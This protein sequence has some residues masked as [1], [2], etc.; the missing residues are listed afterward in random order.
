MK[1]IAVVGSGIAGI[2]TSYYL[3][4]LGFDVS[5]FEAGDHFG[6]H[7]HTH[8]IE[9]K[10]KTFPV[11]TG[12]LVHNDRTYPNLIEF[13]KE[14]EIEVFNSDMS[15]SVIEPNDNISWAGTNLLTVFGQYKNILSPRFYSFVGEILKFNKHGSHYLELAEQ[16]QDLSLGE[17]LDRHNYSENFK[18]WYLLPMGGCIWS[19]PV[20][21]MLEFPAHSFLRFCINHGLLQVTD[22]PQWKTVTGGC[23]VY[24]EKALSKI[25]K[26]Y[27]N[28][29]VLSAM[30]FGNKVKLKTEQR[31]EEFDACFFCG[32]PPQTL[33]IIKD[34]NPK[35]THILK[36]FE[37][38]PNTAVLHHDKTVL[39]VKRFWS[40]WNY[41]A[42]EV[43]DINDE[44]SVS[45]SYLI[46]QLQPLPLAK[47]DAVI[48]TLNPVSEI[49]PDKIWK[50]LEY[51]HPVFDSKAVKAQ[52]EIMKIQGEDN[53]Y[54]AGAWMRYG[55][56]EDGILSAK[57]V[58]N[59]FL[60]KEEESK[61][62]PI[63]K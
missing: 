44:A 3:N 29:P 35:T 39:P 33:N 60:E 7:T 26:K 52:D 19:T 30:P 53:L 57:K 34:L 23:K 25:D 5:L 1:K 49:D 48:V 12:F 14:L 55:F 16:D 31:E 38:Q 32:H 9:F 43:K 4:R 20:D 50:V 13:F 58:V 61:S 47:E 24:V 45:V 37:Y 62:L 59:A 15:F 17:L 2:S 46:N 54:F 27:L 21:K 18:K 36:Q 6:G 10:G 11:D 8:E 51:E 41:R 63:F 22:R 28:E 56:H 42:R 40:A